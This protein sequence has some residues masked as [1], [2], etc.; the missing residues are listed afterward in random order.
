MGT[1]RLQ[2]GECWFE[3]PV[4]DAAPDTRGR[5]ANERQY[6]LAKV[7]HNRL[8]DMF[9]GAVARPLSGAPHVVL[10]DIGRIGTDEIYVAL[11]NS[12]QRF[13]V[14]VLARG[15]ADQ[16]NTMQVEQNLELC[17]AI[18]PT[19]SPR[20]VT[21]QFKTDVVGEVIVMFDLVVVGDEIKVLDEKHYRLV[22]ASEI[23]DED[24]KAMANLK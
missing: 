13:V 5:G 3:I 9:V 12:G 6:I 19:L 17:R 2:P 24:R 14:A 16:I 22:P 4:I 18:F 20:L 21:I 11:R 1:I 8:I 7:R 10:H 23:D 15:E